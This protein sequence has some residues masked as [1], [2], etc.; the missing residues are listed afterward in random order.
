MLLLNYP[1]AG[2]EALATGS[3]SNSEEEYVDSSGQFSVGTP[4]L[5]QLTT[6]FSPV[7]ETIQKLDETPPGDGSEGGKEDV[8]PSEAEL[9]TRQ[10][11]QPVSLITELGSTATSETCSKSESTL[12][13][14][15]TGKLASEEGVGISRVSESNST[16]DENLGAQVSSEEMESGDSGQEADG[17]SQS[18]A[19]EP[20]V[21]DHANVSGKE[22][23]TG[24]PHKE[25]EAVSQAA[26]YA[27]LMV[28]SRKKSEELK[29]RGDL[30]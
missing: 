13:P 1:V 15:S 16:E 11:S 29:A 8:V 3:R 5:S 25:T 10:S 7:A 12:M 9:E 22:Q 30:L 26:R 17:E 6:P 19:D 2:E 28:E 23:E 27:Q 18:A 20:S 4:P 14:D 21:P 24:S